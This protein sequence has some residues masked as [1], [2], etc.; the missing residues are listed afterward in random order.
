MLSYCHINNC[1][2]YCDGTFLVKEKQSDRINET[3]EEYKFIFLVSDD[4][5]IS[6]SGYMFS[7]G[8]LMEE[9]QKSL[10][11][12]SDQKIDFSKRK[13]VFKTKRHKSVSEMYEYFFTPVHSIRF[14]SILYFDESIMNFLKSNTFIKANIYDYKDHP[15]VVWKKINFKTKIDLFTIEELFL[16]FNN[17]CIPKMGDTNLYDVVS[18]CVNFELFV[19]L[20]KKYFDKTF[21]ID[22]TQFISKCFNFI[23]ASSANSI[24]IMKI[25]DLTN[26]IQLENLK[27]IKSALVAL[28]PSS[29]QEFIYGFN[30]HL[31]HCNF[32]NSSLN[33]LKDIYTIYEFN[34]NSFVTLVI[35]LVQNGIN[36]KTIMNGNI[37]KIEGIDKFFKN[38]TFIECLEI[39]LSH[40]Q[41]FFLPTYFYML[42]VDTE[43]ESIYSIYSRAFLKSENKSLFLTSEPT[44]E[45]L[46][47]YRMFIKYNN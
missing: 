41:Y 14:S 11:N 34:A 44:P 47:Y 4:M 16:S 12:E 39:C 37:F 42:S 35:F 6:Y 19:R 7:L 46:S 36:Y 30:K 8:T 26:W 38:K 24:P 1:R 43:H 20:C 32:N 2:I 25:R 33:N 17:T 21:L 31:K 5:F 10:I 27:T 3:E 22:C 40:W 9:K 45:L 15:Y 13:F 29:I 18:S 28:V 23:I